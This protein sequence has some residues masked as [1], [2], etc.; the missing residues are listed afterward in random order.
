MSCGLLSNPLSCSAQ[1]KILSSNPLAA[2]GLHQRSLRF[3][4]RLWAESCYYEPSVSDE[5][6]RLEMVVVPEQDVHLKLAKSFKRGH[7]I[8]NP[9]TNIRM[10]AMI[11]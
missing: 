9:E 10:Q 8:I 1:C 7:M 5:G 3:G 4:E 2:G 11:L 6:S